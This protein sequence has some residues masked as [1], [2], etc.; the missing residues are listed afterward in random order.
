MNDDAVTVPHGVPV[1]R[2]QVMKILNLSPADVVCFRSTFN[3]AN[4][5]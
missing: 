5:R 3:R 1:P 2:V 4:L